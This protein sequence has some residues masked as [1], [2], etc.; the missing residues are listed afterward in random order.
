M[1]ITLG[2]CAYTNIPAA[3]GHVKVIAANGKT[4]AYDPE[5]NVI[6]SESG[7]D[8]RVLQAGLDRAEGSIGTFGRF[9][10]KEDLLLPD[11]LHWSGHNSQIIATG[12]H[13]AMLRDR[14]PEAL[15]EYCR[16]W[17]I[18]DLILEGEDKASVDYGIDAS[19]IRH[20][21]LENI[22]VLHMAKDGF[23]IRDDSWMT[24]LINCKTYDNKVN[25]V[26]FVA[27]DNDKPNGCIIVGGRFMA[28]DG[29]GVY[30]EAGGDIRLMSTSVESTGTAVYVLDNSAHISGSYIE[31]CTNGIYLGSKDK[32]VN[33]TVA[34]DNAFYSVITPITM[35]NCGANTIISGNRV[36]GIP[37]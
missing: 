29:N 12:P 9:Y 17:V 25:G 30:I 35:V 21:H 37:I 32:K 22:N 27:G 11:A 18:R 3:C 1:K 31:A 7:E 26:H 2:S 6:L 4:T 15:K 19:R 10:T 20:A 13:E 36:D 14:N 8:A 28:D 5:G 23:L 24:A 33:W 16:T 34:R